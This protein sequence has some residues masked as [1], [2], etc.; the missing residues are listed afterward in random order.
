MISPYRRSGRGYLPCWL[1]QALFR[2]NTTAG[3]CSKIRPA[4]HRAAWGL[5]LPIKEK[6]G[7]PNS[8]YLFLV[9]V[10]IRQ[11]CSDY[12]CIKE[13]ENHKIKHGIKNILADVI[14]IGV[15]FKIRSTTAPIRR[16]SSKNL[17]PH[18]VAF[19]PRS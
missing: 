3:F 12:I 2:N 14:H 1:A 6:I 4:G 16:Q 17:L 9:P 11:Q 13:V 15:C 8:F 7:Q 5:F 19:A 18:P 10:P